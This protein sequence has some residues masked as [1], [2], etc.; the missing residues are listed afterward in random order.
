MLASLTVLLAGTGLARAQG[1]ADGCCNIPTIK[2]PPVQLLRKEIE[3]CH[4]E[5]APVRI[6]GVKYFRADVAPPTCTSCPPQ[7]PVKYFRCPPPVV[8]AFCCPPP[9]VELFRAEA[10]CPSPPITFR[11]PPITLFRAF[12]ECPS[13]VPP[14]R[15][16]SVT[17][18]A[19]PQPLCP[20][21]VPCP[22]AGGK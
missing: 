15:L 14:V 9:K 18:I 13:E 19:K 6:P 7:P 22:C 1:C 20:I 17:V 2:I 12:A 4:S 10:S 5:S 16:P 11:Q 21:E 8:Q 3:P